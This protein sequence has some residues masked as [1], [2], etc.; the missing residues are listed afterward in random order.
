MVWLFVRIKK[1]DVI[2]RNVP[3]L[4][5]DCGMEGVIIINI[6]INFLEYKSVK[7]GGKRGR[8]ERGGMRK[9]GEREM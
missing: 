7:K 9:K 1:N 4:F 8:K 3:F 5:L 2:R 6:A